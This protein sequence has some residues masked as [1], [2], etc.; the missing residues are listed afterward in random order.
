[1]RRVVK[2]VLACLVGTLLFVSAWAQESAPEAISIN[3]GQTL[4]GDDTVGLEPVAAEY[5][6][7]VSGV[8][9]AMGGQPAELSSVTLKDQTGK[10]YPS[11]KLK[12][13]SRGGM[14]TNGNQNSLT[15][16][17][18]YNFIDDSN[19]GNEACVEVTHVPFARY[20]VYVYFNGDFTEGDANKFPPYEVNGKLYK[21][22][23]STTVQITDFTSDVTAWGTVR[24]SELQ[25]GQNVLKV[26]GQSA[27]TLRIYASRY[28]S[29]EG[30]TPSSPGGRGCIS[31]IQI[32]SEEA[33]PSAFTSTFDGNSTPAG[34]FSGWGGETPSAYVQTPFGKGFAVKN[35]VHPYSDFQAKETFSLALYADIAAVD[36]SDNV[37]KVLA[38]FGTKDSHIALMKTAVATVEVWQDKQ[39][40]GEL[41]ITNDALKAGFHLFAFGNDTTG[42]F[43]SVD[44][45]RVSGDMLTLPAGGLQAGAL[46]GGFG[47]D[48]ETIWNKSVGMIVDEI[49]G[50]DKVLTEDEEVALAK[51]FSL[52]LVRTLTGDADWQAENTWGEGINA[53]NSDATVELTVASDATLTMNADAA[54][55]YLLVEGEGA[56]TFA[57]DKKLSSAS[58]HIATN[59]DAFK[60]VASLG[61]VSVAEGKKL[62]V[63]AMTFPSLNAAGATFATAA[64][65]CTTTIEEMV[66]EPASITV[67]EGSTLVLS[68]KVLPANGLQNAGGTLYA[69][70]T[71]ATLD[72]NGLYDTS[73]E[74][75]TLAAGAV[76]TNGGQDVD[77]NKR[78]WKNL[79]IA[80]SGGAV[81]VSGNTF[82][83]VA[84]YHGAHSLTLNGG[85]LRVAMNAGKSF[86][87]ANL[88][89]RK[90][91]E[92]T[93][94]DTSEA[95]TIQVVS[96]IL[97]FIHGGDYSRVNLNITGGEVL[98]FTAQT[99]GSLSGTGGTLNLNGQTLTVGAFG[100]TDSF[101]GAIV[102]S[103]TLTKVGSGALDLSGAQVQDVSAV[104][105][106]AGT[107]ILGTLR[108]K[109]A[110]VASG[111]TIELTASSAEKRAGQLSLVIA[112]GITLTGVTVKVDDKTA[113]V[114]DD[115]TVSFEKDES[116]FPTWMPTAD[117]VAW[118]T[119]T[120]WT[121]LTDGQVPT[122]GMVKIDLSE[123]PDEITLTL[124]TSAA[125]DY[126]ELVNGG[127]KAVTFALS[128]G[129]SVTMTELISDAAVSIP[130]Q[131]IAEAST[132]KLP[133]KTLT[134]TGT[135][136]ACNAVVKEVGKVVVGSDVTYTPNANVAL[137][138]A[139]DLAG[140]TLRSTVGRT[141]SGKVTLTADSAIICEGGE[142]I[143]S[144]DTR[145][146]LVLNGHT[147]TKSGGQLLKVNTVDLENGTLAV[148]Q[149]TLQLTTGTGGDCSVKDVTLS[150]AAGTDFV[151]YGWLF[152]EGT[153]TLDCAKGANVTM[154]SPVRN[155][156]DKVAS[157][158]KTGAGAV[159]VQQNGEA[160]HCSGAFTVE[161]G[162]LT[163]RSDA[164]IERS[165]L[166][167]VAQG[168][169]LKLAGSGTCHFLDAKVNGHVQVADSA[170][171]RLVA[172][173]A[174]TIQSLNVA[175][176]ASVTLVGKDFT[177]NQLTGGAGA[178]IV[179]DGS[180]ETAMSLKGANGGYT[181]AVTV[182]QG[183]TLAYNA[184]ENVPFGKGT[185]VNDGVVRMTQDSIAQIPPMSGT[186]NLEVAGSARM[187][188]PLTLTG[189]VTVA[190]GKTL[191]LSRH[192]TDF[193][194]APSI[195]GPSL[196][197]GDGAKVVKGE[198]GEGV[199][200]ALGT[201]LSGAGTVEAPVTFAA[202]AVVDA[203][204]GVPTLTQGVT[205][206]TEGTVSVKAPAEGHGIVL[207]ANGLDAT[208][209]ALVDGSARQALTA[210]DTALVLMQ[211]PEGVDAS[212]AA[213][214]A[215]LA[216]ANAANVT[217]VEKVEGDAIDGAAL[218]TD[219]VTVDGS[220]ATVAY[221]F[222]ISRMFT[223]REGETTYLYIAAKVSTDYAEG[224]AVKVFQDGTE[225]EATPVA[226]G[227]PAEAGVKWL[228]VVYPAD[229][230]G[231]HHY[232][233]KAVSEEP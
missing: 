79:A 153:L 216:T 91:A 202:G 48:S 201:T 25:E 9:T 55:S 107:L 74:S 27:D 57:G 214:K 46:Y 204:A 164:K 32:V 92:D 176:D 159:E 95:G 229:I 115:G 43:L 19:G 114:A 126:V 145:T 75:L 177:V 97:R 134:L 98:S 34:W 12:V 183:A 233:I 195:N 110:S 169:T 215:I 117:S 84:P 221:D 33:L 89:A 207:T 15:G 150:F 222:G 116:D 178:L 67:G 188:G 196:V 40:A 82:G 108:P 49:R 144:D 1:M 121:N 230:S 122:S 26:T 29:V 59:V 167:T 127:E 54:L 24:K 162:T 166:L 189:T 198:F 30:F 103:G 119:V 219:V 142:L 182:A 64:G 86:H 200:L 31:A 232:A 2:N 157:L 96:G 45:T 99:F 184:G 131:V 147:L 158:T 18:L 135:S 190:A 143:L 100:K 224:T 4:S 38:A 113:T 94:E 8:G 102:G 186:G 105:L 69:V 66:G 78:Q 125:L 148:T 141:C 56:L 81:T 120:T 149:G 71:G 129:V 226:E 206:P 223:R 163:L 7:C 174:Q 151:A 227:V 231:M 28:A 180:S 124:D 118:G 11:A 160:D 138:Y 80:T 83:G 146:D 218:F 168:A 21:G 16:C 17:L 76:L 212:S 137:P 50:Y 35:G 211:L 185:I 191:T 93:S 22:N 70:E 220:T 199:T 51:T 128:E 65:T 106:E 37:P 77:E 225:V 39:K 41:S 44:G 23:G 156:T 210:T 205:L 228:R 10:S 170:K 104:A 130:A 60:G 85:T 61:E 6:V 13:A 213:G 175:Q 155:R 172:A 109:M 20:T 112:S 3:F 52:S 193:T 179:G 111:T 139:L 171:L 101:S 14:W 165:A 68:T 209:F 132:V 192:Q 161:E 217:N 88:T 90:T 203:S 47:D 140:G 72:V 53:P 136:D 197:L 154:D 181:G 58:T 73:N 208:K 87:M 5:W 133:G 173:E 36:V 62:T 194:E 63:G 152:A 123:V 187:A 42:S